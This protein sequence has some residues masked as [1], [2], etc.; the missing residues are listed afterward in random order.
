MTLRD[1]LGGRLDGARC[2]SEAIGCRVR[3]SPRKDLFTTETQSTPSLRVKF[4]ITFL[5]VLCASALHCAGSVSD[6]V[7]R[8]VCCPPREDLF[9]TEAQSTPSLRKTFN[10]TF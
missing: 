3:W 1:C 2:L 5:S 9:T 7:D 4:N 8:R 10:H 6:G